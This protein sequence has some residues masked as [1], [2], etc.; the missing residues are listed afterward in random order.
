MQIYSYVSLESYT[1]TS[2]GGRDAMHTSALYDNST[3]PGSPCHMGSQGHGESCEKII[4]RTAS[5][6][7][8]VLKDFCKYSRFPRTTA[9]AFTFFGLLYFKN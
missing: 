9:G 5:G 3:T 1:G 8:Q 6:D 2:L 7:I 4:S